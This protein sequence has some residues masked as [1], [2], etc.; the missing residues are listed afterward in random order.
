MSKKIIPIY[1]IDNGKPLSVSNERVADNLLK[2][3]D[4]KGNPLYTEKKSEAIQASKE[5]KGPNGKKG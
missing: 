5:K 4:Y 2:K 1:S 3:R